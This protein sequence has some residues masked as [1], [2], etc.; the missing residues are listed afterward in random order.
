VL[1]LTA[2]DSGACGHDS[3][4]L[5]NSRRDSVFFNKNVTGTAFCFT[6]ICGG[7]SYALPIF[8]KGSVKISAGTLSILAEDFIGFI[9]PLRQ[10]SGL[11]F[12]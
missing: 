5:S 7:R 8:G 12:Y 2:G 3:P 9:N 1:H 4:D 11:Y 10:I 6:T